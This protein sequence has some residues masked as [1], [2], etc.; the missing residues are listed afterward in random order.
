MKAKLRQM[1]PNATD[2]RI[3]SAVILHAKDSD[4]AVEFMRAAESKSKILLVIEIISFQM[5]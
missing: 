2:N 3:G 1:F 4:K 5:E